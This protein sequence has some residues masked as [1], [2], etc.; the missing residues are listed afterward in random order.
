M[1]IDKLQEKQE[2]RS[3]LAKEYRGLVETI[4]ESGELMTAEQKEKLNGWKDDI[5]KIDEEEA[6]RVYAYLESIGELAELE[7]TS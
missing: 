7:E 6:Q 4:D 3:K 2:A 5:G 1:A